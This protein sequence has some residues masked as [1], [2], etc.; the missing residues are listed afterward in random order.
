MLQPQNMGEVDLEVISSVLP[1]L[2]MIGI[3][4][5]CKKI[6]LLSETGTREIKNL[7]TSIVLP[8]ANSLYMIITLGV[9]VFITVAYVK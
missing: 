3:G 8:A 1:I 4:M 5:L 2:I 9:Y 6:N 7:I